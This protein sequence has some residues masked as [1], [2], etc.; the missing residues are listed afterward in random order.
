MT[1]PFDIATGTCTE[2]PSVLPLQDTGSGITPLA[3]PTPVATAPSAAD[4][5]PARDLTGERLGQLAASAADWS[6]AMTAGM[7]ASQ[8]RRQ[9]Y[10]SDVGQHGGAYG[11][12]MVV[13]Q[14]PSGPGVGL[15][16]VQDLDARGLGYG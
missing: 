3:A 9:H 13:P 12:A 1:M 5:T 11:D 6:A 7:G 2:A 14:S 10:G 15:T 4:Q 8:D 16:D